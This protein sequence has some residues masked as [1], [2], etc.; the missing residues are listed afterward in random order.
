VAHQTAGDVPDELTAA[1]AEHDAKAAWAAL[2]PGKQRGLA[3]PGRLRQNP[4]TQQRRAAEIA[5]A[6]KAGD[7]SK[8]QSPKTRRRSA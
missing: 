1:L 5:D 7:I 2:T 3:Y 6:V 4:E 8:Y